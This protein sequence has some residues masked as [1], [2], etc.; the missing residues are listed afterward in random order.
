VLCVHH[1]TRELTQTVAHAHLRAYQAEAA[2]NQRYL[3]AGGAY[4]FQKIVD[5]I[6]EK[7]PELHDKVPVGEP[8]QALP[9]VYQLSTS[10]AKQDLGILEYLPFEE[11]VVDTVKSL[12]A[13][14][15]KLAA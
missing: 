4:S 11:T 9:N 3:I 5:V 10:K 8:G 15:Q 2:A 12:V 1:T 6:R 14:E 7:F 13:L